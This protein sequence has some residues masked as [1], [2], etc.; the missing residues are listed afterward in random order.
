[1]YGCARDARHPYHHNSLVTWETP[2]CILKTVIR[3]THGGRDM[4]IPVVSCG[5]PCDKVPI[6]FEYGRS[7]FLETGGEHR[8]VLSQLVVAIIS[9]SMSLQSCVRN[10]IKA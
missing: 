8:T 10:E 9:A 2:K 3:S 4:A 5:Q 7:V 6:P 1:M